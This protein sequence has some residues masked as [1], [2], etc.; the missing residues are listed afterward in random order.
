MSPINGWWWAGYTLKF[1]Y[2]H[3]KPS[4]GGVGTKGKKKPRVLSELPEHP[5]LN[6]Y[7]Q[8]ISLNKLTYFGLGPATTLAGRTFYGMTQTIVGGSAVKPFYERL[9]ASLYGEINGRFVNIRPRTGQPS[10]SIAT[11]YSEPTR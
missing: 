8:A 9:N 1:V 2:A 4:G 5:V 11:L 10:P 7:V 6:L 3:Q